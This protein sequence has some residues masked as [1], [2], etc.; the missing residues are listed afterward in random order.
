MGKMRGKMTRTRNRDIIPDDAAQQRGT[1]PPANDEYEYE[2]VYVQRYA[3][4]REH[5]PAP[6]YYMDQDERVYKVIRKA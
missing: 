5:Y 6:Y 3:G 4:W 1:Q 2:E